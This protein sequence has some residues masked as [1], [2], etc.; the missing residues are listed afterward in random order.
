MR[1]QKPV[2]GS[3]QCRQPFGER[4]DFYYFAL[5]GFQISVLIRLLW[6]AAGNCLFTALG[7]VDYCLFTVQLQTKQNINSLFAFLVLYFWKGS[8]LPQ[9]HAGL[10]D[11]ALGINIIYTNTNDPSVCTRAARQNQSV[12]FEMNRRCTLT[13][14]RRVTI[15]ASVLLPD[16]YT[17]QLADWLGLEESETWGSLR[18]WA[19]MFNSF[20]FLSST[21]PHSHGRFV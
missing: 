14:W 18:A 1:G 13:E 12:A 9:G 20:F 17:V 2:W 19:T 6:T 5:T 11:K 10:W 4:W 15:K 8:S 7:T 3:E 16:R 21:V